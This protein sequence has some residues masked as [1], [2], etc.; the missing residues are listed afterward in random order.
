M[1]GYWH[2]HWDPTQDVLGWHTY[3]MLWDPGHMMFYRD[4]IATNQI[5]SSNVPWVPC[6]IKFNSRVNSAW[7]NSG[8]VFPND[9]EVSYA[10]VYKQ[11]GAGATIVNPGFEQGT[12]GWSFSGSAAVVNSN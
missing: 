8:T 10:H 3:G 4:G 12:A 7:V 6:Y 5:D 11:V 1:S 9:F 2:S